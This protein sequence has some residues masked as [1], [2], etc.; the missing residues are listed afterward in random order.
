[1]EERL[2]GLQ[3][4]SGGVS[5]SQMAGCGRC[6]RQDH[7]YMGNILG[8]GESLEGK[9]SF[10]KGKAPATARLGGAAAEEGWSGSLAGNLTIGDTCRQLGLS[11]SLLPGTQCSPAAAAGP[12]S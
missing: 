11:S 12:E 1:M 4:R 3:G 2:M 8:A 10:G 7:V 6:S 9:K 5:K